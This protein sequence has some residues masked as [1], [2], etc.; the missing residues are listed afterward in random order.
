MSFTIPRPLQ[1]EHAA[2]P[3]G[4]AVRQRLGARAAAAA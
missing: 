1:D 4:Q 2:M 3:V